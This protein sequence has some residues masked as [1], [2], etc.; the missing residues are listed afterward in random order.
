MKLRVQ[1]PKRT[2]VQFQAD[3]DGQTELYLELIDR[4]QV[5]LLVGE[6]GLLGAQQLL[7]ELVRLQLRV[8]ASIL[9]LAHEAEIAFEFLDIVAVYA[10]LRRL[11]ER[12]Q[13]PRHRRRKGDL[14]ADL[15][16][17]TRTER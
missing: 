13:V 15:A 16:R 11:Q 1:R 14:Q 2:V 8:I 4:L 6:E 10:H 5:V 3:F 7:L 9:Q 12:R 17:W